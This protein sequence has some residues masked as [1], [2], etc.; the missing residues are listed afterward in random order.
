[1][2]GCGLFTTTKIK[3]NDVIAP[4]IGRI[5][6]TTAT[7]NGP[8]TMDGTNGWKI[9]ASLKRG[10]AAMANHPAP[11]KHSNVDSILMNVPV[12]FN[13]HH[14]TSKRRI[15][16]EFHNRGLVR[17]PVSL[18]HA[19]YLGKENIPWLVAIHPIAKGQEILLDYGSNAQRI[20]DIKH[21][22]LPSLCGLK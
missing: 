2:Y 5:Q 3:R 4:Y 12:E 20:F 8:Y 9:D 13:V 18:L 1:M 15:G 19:R 6:T 7:K 11:I 22:T 21:S 17:F 10:W 14:A 16:I